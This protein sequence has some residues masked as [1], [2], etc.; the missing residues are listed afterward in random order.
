MVEE[1]KTAHHHQRHRLLSMA[2]SVKA[3]YSH[4]VGLS[5]S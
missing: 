4:L 3:F 2:L 5:L 1:C